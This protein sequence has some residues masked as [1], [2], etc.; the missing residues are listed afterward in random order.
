MRRPLRVWLK[1]GTLQVKKMSRKERGRNWESRKG[2]NDV[3]SDIGR[4]CDL[5]EMAQSLDREE[6]QMVK[7]LKLCP[8][9]IC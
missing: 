8:V 3:H 9:Q 4:E 5:S 2:D 7:V 6:I 1:A